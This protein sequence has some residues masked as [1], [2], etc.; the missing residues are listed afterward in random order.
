MDRAFGGLAC[1]AAAAIVTD[2]QEESG[3][4][5]GA[6]KLSPTQP[7]TDKRC[8]VFQQLA[9]AGIDK[10]VMT[11]EAKEFRPLLNFEKRRRENG[12]KRR[13]AELDDMVGTVRG[14]L[15]NTHL[16]EMSDKE[17]F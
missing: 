1:D 8:G 5:E 4:E 13:R 12:K 6:H 16:C 17:R 9:Y 2:G 11:D 14:L 15:L 3:A 7:V 10:M